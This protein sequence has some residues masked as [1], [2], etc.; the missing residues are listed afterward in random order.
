MLQLAGTQNA[1]AHALLGPERAVPATI[2]GAARRAADR[3]FAVYRNNVITGLIDALAQRFPVVCRLVGE[4]FF[5]AMARVYVTAQPPSSPLMM[6]Y[7]GTFP[8]F[9]DAFAPA[10]SLPYLGD[11]ARL[12][13]AR[14][15]AY[16]AADA[17]PATPQI[18]T[19][20]PA[21]QLGHLRVR[22]HPSAAIVASAHPIVSIWQVNADPDHAV[23][24]AP[25][26]A[27]AALVARPFTDVEVRRLPPGAAAFMSCLLG[28][29]AMAEAVEAGASASTD[30][31]LVESL[32]VLIA[33]NVVIGIDGFAPA[34]RPKRRTSSRRL[35]P[36]P[37]PRPVDAEHSALLA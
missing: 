12:E 15:R 18:F 23:P 5:R 20:L 36:R 9:I 30:F 27:E 7:G 25:W 3:R 17:V 16:H 32:A 34:S 11:V 22:V 14:G 2:R 4:E 24:I 19:G 28:H 6:L 8:N 29:G 10:A 1:F 21:E 37:A 35:R 31:H 33:A 13:L 26:T